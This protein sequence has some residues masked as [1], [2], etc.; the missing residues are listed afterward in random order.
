MVSFG[1]C[2]LFFFFQA[3]VLEVV[4]FIFFGVGVIAIDF[5]EDLVPMVFLGGVSFL[6]GASLTFILGEVLELEIS[7]PPFRFL[8]LGTLRA[9]SSSSS[10]FGGTTLAPLGFPD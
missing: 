10:S 3:T 4:I 8:L 9:H 7:G 1:L 5:E 2:P 6:G